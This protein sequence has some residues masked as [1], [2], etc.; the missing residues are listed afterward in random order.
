M[1]V[2]EARL[3]DAVASLGADVL[4]LQEVDRGQPRSRRL[5]ITAVAARAMGAKAS[6]FVPSLIGDPAA[7]WRPADDRDE[8]SPDAYGIALVTRWPVQE[9]H[10]L[11]L[12]GAAFVR[13]PVLIPGSRRLL[14]LRDEPRVALAATLR[15]PHGPMTVCTTH[16][17]F[18]P[19][20]N[21]AQLVRVRNWLRQLPGPTVLL[22]DLN[23]PAPLVR[24]LWGGQLLARARSYPVSRPLV[25]W[26]HIL[27]GGALPVVRS[28]STRRLAVS[29]HAAV[30]VDLGT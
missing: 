10:V 12:S 9:W 25:Q 30:V 19:G 1:L 27:G 3:S 26:D 13:A 22:G 7:T 18:V 14:M 17:S 15:T 20:V 16:L 6:R 28:A 11:R 29:D 23:L 5:D 2:D 24:P 8:N 21:V 4:G